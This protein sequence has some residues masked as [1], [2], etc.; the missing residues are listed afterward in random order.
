L[1]NLGKFN[2]FKQIIRNLGN[3]NPVAF[4]STLTVAACHAA[5]LHGLQKSIQAA[6]H[7]SR[8]M[9]MLNSALNENGGRS[10]IMSIG[11]AIALATVEVSWKGFWKEFNS[12]GE[13][14]YT[15]L[16]WYPVG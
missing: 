4:Q 9:Q 2:P 3:D 14:T 10:N 8:L 1:V 11:A 12:W 16:G 5:S 15:N 7:K 13:L 6:V